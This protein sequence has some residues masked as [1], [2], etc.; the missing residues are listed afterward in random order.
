M[1]GLHNFIENSVLVE[2]DFISSKQII[3][4][5]NQAVHINLP[6]HS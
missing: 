4:K 5:E 1:S 2:E 6:V 3:E